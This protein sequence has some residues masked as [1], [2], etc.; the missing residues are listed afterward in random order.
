MIL[1]L[2][3]LKMIL[4]LNRFGSGDFDFDLKSLFSP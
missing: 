1:I 3:R 4:I 2:N